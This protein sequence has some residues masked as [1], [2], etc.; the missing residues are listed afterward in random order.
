MRKGA[1]LPLFVTIFSVGSPSGRAVVALASTELFDPKYW[2]LHGRSMASSRVL[3]T[4]TLLNNNTVLVTG[5]LDANAN[6]SASAEVYNPATATFA[7]TGNLPT[8]IW[9]HTATLL[10]NGQVLVAGGITANGIVVSTAEVFD[11][12]AGTFALTGSMVSPRWEYTATLFPDGTVLV[13]GGQANGGPLSSAEL[14]Q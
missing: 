10:P 2:H 1:C 7:T 4:A 14:Y 9:S 3:H 11:P 13:V 12:M 5:G 8:A 6:P